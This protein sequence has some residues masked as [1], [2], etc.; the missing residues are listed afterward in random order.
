MTYKFKRSIPI[1]EIRQKLCSHRFLVG[2]SMTACHC[3]GKGVIWNNY[4]VNE[5]WHPKLNI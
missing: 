1:L 5:Q 4:N 2:M 3:H